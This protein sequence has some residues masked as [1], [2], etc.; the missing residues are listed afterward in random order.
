MVDDWSI[1]L[2]EAD[3]AGEVWD[4]ALLP[5]RIVQWLELIGNGDIPVPFEDMDRTKA[6]PIA[7]WLAQNLRKAGEEFPHERWERDAQEYAEQEKKLKKLEA[8]AGK[9][10]ALPA[11]K[12]KR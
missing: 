9:L 7:A 5:S 10:R 12:G 3:K 6:V 2:N 1:Y 11:A 8:E 4:P